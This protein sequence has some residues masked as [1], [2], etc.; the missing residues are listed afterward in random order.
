MCG[1]SCR[2]RWLKAGFCWRMYQNRCLPRAFETACDPLGPEDLSSR[3]ICLSVDSGPPSGCWRNS[4]LWQIGCLILL[5]WTH[6]TLLS[7][8]FC[9]QNP[10]GC[11]T[12]I[13][14]PYICPLLQNGPP[15]PP[16]SCGSEKWGWNWVDGRQPTHTNQYLTGL[17]Q[18]SIRHEGLQMEKEKAV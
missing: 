18:A 10:K 13:W 8:A 16:A 3:K 17:L 4:G 12:Q 14:M 1:R 6:W 5:T 11:L 7:D 15:P 2:F 9:R